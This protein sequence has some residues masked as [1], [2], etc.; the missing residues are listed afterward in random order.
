MIY[1]KERTHHDEIRVWLTYSTYHNPAEKKT[2]SL[3]HTA[4]ISINYTT[5][6]YF[7]GI[8]FQSGGTTR[9]GIRKST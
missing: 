6:F 9:L 4:I 5:K 1:R 7:C 3:N 8:N 2:M